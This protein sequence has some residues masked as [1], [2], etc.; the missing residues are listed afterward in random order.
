M[1]QRSLS[2]PEP[3][4]ETFFLW[5][6]RQTGKSTLLRESY[7]GCRWVDLL[8]NDVF[9]RYA[10]RP[11]LLRLEIGEDRQADRAQIVID[12][13]QK[14]PALLDEVHWLIENRRLH[15]ALC[16]SSA[17]RVRRGAANLLGGRALRYELH[18]LTAG[19]LGEAFDLDRILNQ[20]YLPRL[21]GSSRP[22][23]LLDAYIA[24]YLREEILAEGL[25][26]NLPAF[27]GFLEAAALSDGSFV[28]F[29]NIAREC[30][31]SVPTAKSYFQIL[32][33]TLLGCWLPA[34]RKRV[35]RRVIGAPKFYFAD[36]GVVNRLTRR[37]V[38]ERGSVAYGKA[39][40]NWVFHELASYVSYRDVDVNLAHWRLPSGIEVDFVLGPMQ[41]AIEAKATTNV[42]S[43]HLKGLRTLSEEHPGLGHRVVVCLE[44]RAW[45]SDDGISVLPASTFA[46]RLWRGDL[47]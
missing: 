1:I 43:H 3:G 16:G 13:I 34:Y 44:P 47:L 12:E 24:D 9:L 22:R 2:L 25:V 37:G 10:R 27:S 40:E 41:V 32:E 5:G 26:R 14:V 18:G 33:D 42:V 31:V 45:R 23:R 6:P 4:S 21:Y 15:F 36:V 7:P 46:Q 8:K 17:R 35:K 38:V 39:F 19:E 30:G 11:E 28:N 29:S 20:G